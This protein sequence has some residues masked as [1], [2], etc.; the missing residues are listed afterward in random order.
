MSYQRFSPLGATSRTQISGDRNTTVTVTKG[1][2][3]QRVV[4]EGTVV[5]DFRNASHVVDRGSAVN[6]GNPD[7]KEHR[8]SQ[9]PAYVEQQAALEQ[10]NAEA[11]AAAVQVESRKKYITIGAVAVAAGA[12]LL[13]LRKKKGT[14]P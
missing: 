12:M 2:T 14:S 13:I 10:Q 4:A 9:D 11:Q 1:A 8:Q 3:T 7:T 5:K 6:Y